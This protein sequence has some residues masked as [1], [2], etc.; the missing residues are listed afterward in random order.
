MLLS[1]SN[2]RTSFVYIP[3]HGFRSQAYLALKTLVTVL[4][5][6]FSDKTENDTYIPA[7]TLVQ[8]NIFLGKQSYGPFSH[9]AGAFLT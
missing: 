5:E 8:W 9:I 2:G 4:K 3:C 7:F 1:K 6:H